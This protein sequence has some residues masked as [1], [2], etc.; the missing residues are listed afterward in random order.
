MLGLFTSKTRR[1][2][3][4]YKVVKRVKGTNVTISKHYTKKA[5]KAACK[6]GCTVMSL[7]RKRKMTKRRY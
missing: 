3:L 1:K 7:S 5:A 2:T 6:K 4:K